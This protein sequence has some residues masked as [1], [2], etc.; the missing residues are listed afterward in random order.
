MKIRLFIVIF[1][2]ELERREVPAF[3][4]SVIEQVDRE[5]ILF[6]NHYGNNFR[7]GYPL[8]QY[9]LVERNPAIVCIN[10]GYDESLKLFENVQWNFKIKDRNIRADIKHLSFDYFECESCAS[11]VKYRIQNW[12]A[13]N[14][15]NYNRFKNIKNI[16]DRK[17]FVEKIL[18][19]NILSFAKGVNWTIDEQIK[20]HINFLPNHRMF[21]FKNNK[22]AG[23]DLNFSTNVLLP[24]NI[25]LGKSVSRG[26]GMIRK[27]G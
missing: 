23:F 11:P 26:F 10:S 2:F 14:E 9:K 27:V 7:Y 1:D 8:I 4:G 21:N 20:V 19:G 16:T 6:H 15:Q 12:F 18:I 13:L 17:Q 24:D 5:N 25:G 22:M 3:R